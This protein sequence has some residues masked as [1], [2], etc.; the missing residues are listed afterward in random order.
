LD[1]RNISQF[2]E[3]VD[4]CDEFPINVGRDFDDLDRPNDSKDDISEKKLEF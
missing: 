3:N 4:L 2:L 1:K